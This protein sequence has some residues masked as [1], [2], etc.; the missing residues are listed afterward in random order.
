MRRTWGAFFVQ[1]RLAVAGL[2]WVLSSALAYAA[3]NPLVTWEGAVTITDIGPPGCAPSGQ[4]FPKK[5]DTARA[6]FRPRLKPDEDKSALSL[7]FPPSFLTVYIQ[8]NTNADPNNMNGAGNVATAMWHDQ[9]YSA[10][11]SFSAYNFVVQP[12]SITRNVASIKMTGQFASFF[13]C[14]MN[15]L[16]TFMRRP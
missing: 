13:G 7:Q 6:I 3:N 5:G 16:G 8:N 12:A 2:T 1:R 15:F 4:P 14:Q 10:F 9:A 11:F